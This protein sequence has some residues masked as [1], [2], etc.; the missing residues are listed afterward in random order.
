M[1]KLMGHVVDEDEFRHEVW[2]E[3]HP[4]GTIE[5]VYL[6]YGGTQTADFPY[7]QPDKGCELCEAAQMVVDALGHS[8]IHLP[9]LVL[10]A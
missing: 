6:M 7:N 10:S 4:D 9:L 8:T 3:T 2:V 1:Q 5:Q